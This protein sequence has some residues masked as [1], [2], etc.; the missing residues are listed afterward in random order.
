MRIKPI[1]LGA[2]LLAC[3][4]VASAN[5]FM[6]GVL[7]VEAGNAQYISE[8]F[9]GRTTTKR[10]NDVVARNFRASTTE[11][12]YRQMQEYIQGKQRAGERYVCTRVIGNYKREFRTLPNSNTPVTVK[13]P[14]EC[15]KTNINGRLPRFLPVVISD[16]QADGY[17]YDRFDPFTG[18]L[19]GGGPIKNYKLSSGD[20]RQSLYTPTSDPRNR[21]WNAYMEIY[22]ANGGNS[23]DPRRRAY[24]CMQSKSAVG[25]QTFMTNQTYTGNRNGLLAQAPYVTRNALDCYRQ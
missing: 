21:S 23:A 7:E 8:T 5:D 16:G 19:F 4:S 14:Q 6:P 3:T 20:S 22:R 1:L 17:E 18:K 10:F 2:G 15:L 9:M 25:M 12:V 13:S 24:M 11:P